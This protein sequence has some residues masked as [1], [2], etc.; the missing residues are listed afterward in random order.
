MKR[1]TWNLIL[2]I[3]LSL[4]SSTPLVE[5]FESSP[6][7]IPPIWTLYVAA[8]SWNW[9]KYKH[10]WKRG[11]RGQKL[12]LAWRPLRGV[13]RKVWRNCRK[14]A[15]LLPSFYRRFEGRVIP[16]ILLR[17]VLRR[18]SLLLRSPSPWAY[19]LNVQSFNLKKV[20][21]WIPNH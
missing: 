18:G 8:P 19:W 7:T 13:Q 5:N 9:L 12:F 2:T 16:C 21:A 6:N 3:L 1:Q 11:W 14:P 10:C 15:R 20:C 17:Q 4:M